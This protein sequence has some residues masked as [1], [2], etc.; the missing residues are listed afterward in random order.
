MLDMVKLHFSDPMDGL[1]PCCRRAPR[2][3]ADDG[4]GT[5]AC[6]DAAQVSRRAEATW[7]GWLDVWHRSAFLVGMQALV[8]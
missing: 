2:E 1:E 5:P 6:A 7:G 8:M 3:L 4:L